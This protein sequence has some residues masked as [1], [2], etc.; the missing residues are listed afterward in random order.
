MNS[1]TRL[2][3]IRDELQPMVF[4]LIKAAEKRWQK[5]RGKNQLPKIIQGVIFTNGIES[6][7]NQIH[8]A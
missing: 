2:S 4:M 3:G 5:L 8:A 7:A 6:D 1:N